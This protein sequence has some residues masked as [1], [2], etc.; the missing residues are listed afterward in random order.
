[1]HNAQPGANVTDHAPVPRWGWGRRPVPALEG[2]PRSCFGLGAGAR[3]A[4][5]NAPA[6]DD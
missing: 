2:L 4:L 6:L 1:M 3:T 5:V